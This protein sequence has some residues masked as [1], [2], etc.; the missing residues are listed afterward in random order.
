[1]FQ[2]LL[3]IGVVDA[4]ELFSISAS[5]CGSVHSGCQVRPEEV[6]I[7]WQLYW[8]GLYNWIIAL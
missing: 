8:N 4:F 2:I 7:S 6:F 3:R 5:V 1:M